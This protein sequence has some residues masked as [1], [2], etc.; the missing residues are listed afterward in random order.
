[1]KYENSKSSKREIDAR[2]EN[3]ARRLGLALMAAMVL[4]KPTLMLKYR[5]MTRR[6]LGRLHVS[7]KATIRIGL[8]ASMPAPRGRAADRRAIPG[9]GCFC[10]R[11]L[12]KEK[13]LSK[14]K[15]AGN[16][17][18]RAHAGMRA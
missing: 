14:R 11:A 13:K 4:L 10:A 12:E 16:E 18:W 2:S 8:A 3:P 17:A 6:G 1:M 15:K 9:R 5:L 7:S